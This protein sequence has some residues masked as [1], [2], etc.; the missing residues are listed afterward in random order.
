MPLQTDLIRRLRPPGVDHGFTPHQEQEL[1]AGIYRRGDR[2]M[3]W[4]LVT[5]FILG[6]LLAFFHQTWAATLLV[7]GV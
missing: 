2:L 3:V 1:M 5:H 7:G 6:L 4:F